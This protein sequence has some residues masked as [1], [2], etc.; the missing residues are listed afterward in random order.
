MNDKVIVTR[1]FEGIKENINLFKGLA[2]Q[3]LSFYQYVL[4]DL[5]DAMND[6]QQAIRWYTKAEQQYVPAKNF[7]GWEYFSILRTKENYKQAVYWFRQTAEEYIDTQYNIGLLFLNGYGVEKNF[8]QAVYWLKRAADK[9]FEP[10]KRKLNALEKNDNCIISNTIKILSVKE[11]EQNVGEVIQKLK[12][13]AEQDDI[14]A[15]YNL[16]YLY[17]DGKYT[18]PDFEQAVY[19]YKKA[20]EKEDMF[21]QYN[22]AFL[23]L[24]G[25]GVTTNIQQAIY[26]FEKSDSQGNPI[27]LKTLLKLKKSL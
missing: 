21:A 16:G 1:F 10:A 12:D 26:W 27:A 18:E 23:Y 8:E 13:F 4:G 5:Y 9:G 7:L 19:W 24:L 3:G 17:S 14:D 25:Q 15:Q 6:K 22:L 11:I 2:E 20:A